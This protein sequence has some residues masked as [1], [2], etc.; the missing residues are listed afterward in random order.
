M[1]RALAWIA[2]LAGASLLVY[3]VATNTEW[4]EVKIPLPPKGEAATNPFYAAQRFAEA[5][6]ARTSWDRQLAVPATDAVIVVSAWHW[7]LTERRRYS[8]ERWVESGGRLVVT[9]R[10][11]GG[12]DEFERWSGIT[13]THRRRGVIARHVRVKSSPAAVSSQR[14][15]TARR[16]AGRRRAVRRVRRRSRDLPRDQA[17][18]VVGPARRDG[19]AGRARG[20][21]PW[22]GHGDQR[23]AF[24]RAESSGRRPRPP[25][26]RRDGPAQGRRGALPFRRRPS[27]A[28]R[29]A[30]DTRQPG[31]RA[32]VSPRS[33]LACGGTAPGSVR[34]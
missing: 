30:V 2:A 7:D 4:T 18:G 23:L 1:N 5:L 22:L 17:E 14:S 24:Q 34:S 29:A 13:R 15:A 8:L 9:G 33:R 27:V 16:R 32:S 10:L 12:E 26:R 11:A 28:A 21:R 20:G 25:V 31:R 3:W 6:G 19:D